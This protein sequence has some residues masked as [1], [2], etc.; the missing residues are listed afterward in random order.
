M[1]KCLFR[2]S[3]A[4]NYLKSFSADSQIRSRGAF[5]VSCYLN[6]PQNFNSFRTILMEKSSSK[7]TWKLNT[8]CDCVKRGMLTA[9]KRKVLCFNPQS[10]VIDSIFFNIHSFHLCSCDICSCVVIWYPFSFLVR[11]YFSWESFGLNALV[12]LHIRIQ[13]RRLQGW[14]V[15]SYVIFGH[16]QALRLVIFCSLQYLRQMT[17]FCNSCA[18]NQSQINVSRILPVLLKLNFARGGG[19]WG[20]FC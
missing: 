14:L 11:Q 3:K 15:Q 4:S 17:P 1:T 2:L 7:W 10:C 13:T 18:C 8:F 6:I 12:V 9:N 19:E 5:D 16:H 20:H